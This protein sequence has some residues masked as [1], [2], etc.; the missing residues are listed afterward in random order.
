MSVVTK[1]SSNPVATLAITLLTATLPAQCE[2]LSTLT[3]DL[4]Q[5]R[6]TV[7]H[8]SSGDTRVMK[9]GYIS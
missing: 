5:G 6:Q 7:L 4:V 1:R 9:C 2:K 3:P 8:R